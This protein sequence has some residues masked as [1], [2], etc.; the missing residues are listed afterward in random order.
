MGVEPTSAV[1]NTAPGCHLQSISPCFFSL[2]YIWVEYWN[3]TNL[4]GVASRHLKKHSAN[5]AFHCVP[6]VRFE[7]TCNHLSFQRLMRARE[8]FGII[9]WEN[10][11]IWTHDYQI[12]SL[13]LYLLS[14]KLHVVRR[15]RDSNPC[16]AVNDSR[17]SRP[18]HLPV[19]PNLQVL[20]FMRDSNSH[21]RR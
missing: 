5:S 6:K 9:Y 15:L 19:L 13:A 10:D 17:F 7:L 14:Y 21:P 12:H 2:I 8:Y 4:D 18:V 16:A 3:R 20:W 11:G 1:C